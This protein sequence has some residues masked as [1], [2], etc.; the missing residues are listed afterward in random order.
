ML[1]HNNSTVTIKRWNA[2]ATTVKTALRTYIYELSDDLTIINSIDG[3][4]TMM[5][6]I[7]G[8]SDI[9]IGDKITD[10][11][12]VN[13]IVKKVNQRVSIFKKFYEVIMHKWND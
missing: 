8:Y 12:S 9:Q 10:Q 7:T 11:N 6:M 13:Y 2:F 3:W 4:M 1:Y 5:K